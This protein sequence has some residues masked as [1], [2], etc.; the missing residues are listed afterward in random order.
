MAQFAAQPFGT[1]AIGSLARSRMKRQQTLVPPAGLGHHEPMIAA[2]EKLQRTIRRWLTGLSLCLVLT[3]CSTVPDIPPT[4]PLRHRVAVI[5][6]QQIGD[7]YQPNM[8]GPST[9]DAAGLAY[10]AYH[11]AGAHLPRGLRAQL[12]TGKPIALKHARPADLAF[13]RIDDHRGTPHDTVG[14][15]ISTKQMV[16]AHRT[17]NN[18]GS[19]QT[20]NIHDGYWSQHLLGVIQ[21]L[22]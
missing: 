22:P 8:A 9:Y 12:N 7:A 2:S 6:T 19:V 10:Y 15:L 13:F 21:I 5:A 16:I 4:T 18:H 20:A 3:A 1:A 14:V 11:Q 17:G